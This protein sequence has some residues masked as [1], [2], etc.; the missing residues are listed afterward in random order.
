ME[1]KL[2]WLGPTMWLW[3]VVADF[4][5]IGDFDDD[6]DDDERSGTCLALLRAVIM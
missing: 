1:E 3:R 6:V 4:E 2:R 5:A